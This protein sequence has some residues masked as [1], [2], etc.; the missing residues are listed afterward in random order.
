MNDLLSKK[1]TQK[2][3]EIL[4]HELDVAPNQLTA[5]AKLTEDLGADSLSKVSIIMKLE[6]EFG[7]TVPDERA[8]KV[9]TVG[10]V[11]ELLAAILPAEQRA[12]D[13][14]R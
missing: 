13:S 4:A 8:E 11:F 2:V 10:D 1:D 3:M 5:D 12:G 7:V 9:Q 14:L 6:D